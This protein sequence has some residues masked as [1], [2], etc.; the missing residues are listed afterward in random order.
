MKRARLLRWAVG[1]SAAIAL[2]LGV[3]AVGHGEPAAVLHEDRSFGLMQPVEIAG[4]SG[5]AMEPFLAW[6]GRWL[7]FNRRNGPRD[8]TDL[9]VARRIDDRHF[10]FVGPP[11]VANSAALEGVPS[12]DRAGHLFLVSTRE[13][14]HSSRAIEPDF[15]W[16]PRGRMMAP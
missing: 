4:Y 3:G 9:M 1:A 16:R 15:L 5:D 8:Q 2:A 10:A 12:V 6:D 7:L 13:F 14:E 11:A